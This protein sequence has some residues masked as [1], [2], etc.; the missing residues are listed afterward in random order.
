MTTVVAHYELLNES[1]LF[2]PK[3]LLRSL[4]KCWVS[5]YRWEQRHKQVDWLDDKL[6]P[7]VP[8]H[9]SKQVRVI[10]HTIF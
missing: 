3:S 2:S 4:M 1:S 7:G 10:L 9:C 5:M 6:L 8:T